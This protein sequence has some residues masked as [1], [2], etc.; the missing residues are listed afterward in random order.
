M[1][2][3]LCD[4]SPR[5]VRSSDGPLTIDG[6]LIA[7]TKAGAKHRLSKIAH[8]GLRGAPA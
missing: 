4:D 6:A 7:Q 5:P 3:F 8:F 1:D 2:M